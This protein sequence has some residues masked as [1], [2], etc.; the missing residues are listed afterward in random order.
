V[1]IRLATVN[2]VPEENQSASRQDELS[3]KEALSMLG[4]PERRVCKGS[5]SIIS[6]RLAEQVREQTSPHKLVLATW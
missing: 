2:C 3:A 5:A 1:Y 4:S 6:L